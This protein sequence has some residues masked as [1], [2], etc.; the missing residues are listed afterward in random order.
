MVN[1]EY[2]TEFFDILNKC[3]IQYVLIKN[4]DDRIPE[5]VE[6]GD[7]VDILIHPTDYN[8]FADLMN[9]EGYIKV[10]NEFK[11]YYF[12]YG[13]K[14]DL[15]LKKNEAYFHAYDRLACTSFTNMGM[16]K[17]PLDDY[18][19]N[20]IWKTRVWDNYN[21]WWIM[22]NRIILLYLLVRSVF[23][24]KFFKSKYIREIEKRIQLLDDKDF[25]YMC[26]K[27]FF[28]FTDRLI[29]MVKSKQYDNIIIEY[30]TFTD[31]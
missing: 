11:K 23:D 28:K 13:L 18:I 2:I 27:V 15:Y 20:Y 10:H 26:E 24:K 5:S 29:E 9:K 1:K 8:K 3:N 16:A 25:V 21:R 4:D 22:D 14:P 6:D 31:Y 17:I 12:I 30:K 7:D 19:Q